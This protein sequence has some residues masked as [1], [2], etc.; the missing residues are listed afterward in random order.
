MFGLQDER[1]EGGYYLGR[2]NFPDGYPWA[3]P[4]IR[5]I[6]DTGRYE[7]GTSICLTISE[8]HPESW[9]PALTGRSIITALLSFTCDDERA[10]GTIETSAA[11]KKKIAQ[12]SKKKV[13]EQHNVGTKFSVSHFYNDETLL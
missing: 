11:V 7:T 3:P 13:M 10:S 5:C 2:I 4:A 6:T 9:N 12:A 1:Y 8:H